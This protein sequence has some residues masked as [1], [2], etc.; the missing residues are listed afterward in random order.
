M[1]IIKIIPLIFY[2]FFLANTN[3]IF[4]SVSIEITE[5][6]QFGYVLGDVFVRKLKLK[7][8]QGRSVLLDEKKL[9]G[10]I[11]NWLS[12]RKVESKQLSRFEYFIKI[13]YQVVNVPI[14]PLMIVVPG[15]EVTTSN[16]RSQKKIQ[17][18][19]LLVTLAPVTP[20][21][22]ANRGGLSNI[23][24]NA[25]IPTIQS[26]KILFRILLWLSLLI[27]PILIL[28]YSWAPW[29][30]IFFTKKHPFSIAHSKIKKLEDLPDLVFW[31]ESLILF[32][33]ALN[34]TAKKTIF[35]GSLDDF[36]LENSKYKCLSKEI[37]HVF[38]CSRKIFYES[39]APPNFDEKKLLIKLMHNLAMIEKRL[40]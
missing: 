32:H 8:N 39:E 23:Q 17:I 21:I 13:Q 22:V 4:A 29:Q 5:P 34:S 20:K 37:R 31:K 33:N 14:K 30:K 28:F 9:T 40:D 10:R 16:G 7:F 2:L 35:V 1:R 27:I 12:I 26:E 24:P 36:F 11:N 25:S 19:E 15:F 3:A 18:E 6:R 38:N